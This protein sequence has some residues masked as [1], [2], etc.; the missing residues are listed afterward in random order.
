MNSLFGLSE[1]SIDAV[2]STRQRRQV[3]NKDQNN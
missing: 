2:N 3:A 1:A